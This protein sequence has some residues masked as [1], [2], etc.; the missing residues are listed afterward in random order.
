MDLAPSNNVLLMFTANHVFDNCY[1]RELQGCRLFTKNIPPSGTNNE[2]ISPSHQ[3]EINS[4]DVKSKSKLSGQ[5]H[6]E[7]EFSDIF[8]KI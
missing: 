2:E 7:V 4:F 1:W 5:I 3:Y 8:L 6:F